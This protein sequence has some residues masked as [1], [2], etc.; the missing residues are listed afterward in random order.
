LTA[1]TR[2]T[3][4]QKKTGREKSIKKKVRDGDGRGKYGSYIQKDVEK[5]RIAHLE[6]Y[7]GEETK[8]EGEQKGSNQTTLPILFGVRQYRKKGEI[9]IQEPQRGFLSCVRGEGSSQKSGMEEDV[10]GRRVEQGTSK[11]HKKE[12]RPPLLKVRWGK[13]EER[14]SE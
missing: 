4:H 12:K 3:I 1:P 13:K 11:G 7:W 8:E 5:V 6:D 14:D 10:H 2:M 9:R